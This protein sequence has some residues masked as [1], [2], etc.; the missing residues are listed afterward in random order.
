MM[1]SSPPPMILS[2]IKPGIIGVLGKRKVNIRISQ[3]MDWMGQ[4]I[5]LKKKAAGEIKTMNIRA[6]TLF[7]N[8][9][10]SESP[11]NATAKIY[12]IKIK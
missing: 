10:L 2:L 11:A 3:G 7:R 9:K 1:E 4:E 6:F 8:R 5:P 12:G